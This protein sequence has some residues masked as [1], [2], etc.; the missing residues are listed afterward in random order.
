LPKIYFPS[1]DNAIKQIFFLVCTH[2]TNCPFYLNNNKLHILTQIINSV[3][4]NYDFNYNSCLVGYGKGVY[5]LLLPC[6]FSQTMSVFNRSEFV[7]NI[8]A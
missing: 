6:V 2:L 7:Y 8:V 4:I 5:E 1:L 3:H